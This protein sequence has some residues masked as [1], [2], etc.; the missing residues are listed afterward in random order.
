MATVLAALAALAA[1][2][3]FRGQRR[4]LAEQRTFIAD[5]IEVESRFRITNNAGG[6][7]QRGL[8]FYVV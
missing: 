8:I 5:Q 2:R 6:A 4:Q 7:E 3:A 1:W